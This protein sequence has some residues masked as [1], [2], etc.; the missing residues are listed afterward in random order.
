MNQFIQRIANYI[1]NVSHNNNQTIFCVALSSKKMY[2]TMNETNGNEWEQMGTNHSTYRHNRYHHK[3][4]T[5]SY[6]HILT[7]DNCNTHKNNRKS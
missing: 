5:K 6:T 7:N 2:T 1:A 3:L 4:I